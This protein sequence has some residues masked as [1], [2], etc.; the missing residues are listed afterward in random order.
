MT[1]LVKSVKVKQKVYPHYLAALLLR[2]LRLLRKFLLVTV[3][4]KGTRPKLKARL[5]KPQLLYKLEHLLLLLVVAPLTL[6]FAT[7]LRV[8]LLLPQPLVQRAVALVRLLFPLLVL[9]VKFAVELRLV[10]ILVHFHV[11]PVLSQL[12][13]L[14]LNPLLV[15]KFRPKF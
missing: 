6:H 3:V 8:L 15:R 1:N 4:V 2:R 7:R 9:P 13:A 14:K 10:A 12:V 5:L 11:R